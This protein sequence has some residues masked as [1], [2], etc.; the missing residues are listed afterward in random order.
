V[1]FLWV[2]EEKIL[3]GEHLNLEMKSI[4]LDTFLAFGTDTKNILLHLKDKK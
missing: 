3:N 2:F 4:F 1:I